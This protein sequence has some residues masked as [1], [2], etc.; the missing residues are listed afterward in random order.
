MKNT[1]IFLFVFP[2][3]GQFVS[4]FFCFCANGPFTPP[5]LHL[6]FAV[7][8]SLTVF[9][10]TGW[11]TDRRSVY[12]EFLGLVS[13]LRRTLQ[14]TVAGCSYSSSYIM[15]HLMECSILQR[16]S[17]NNVGTNVPHTPGNWS[18]TNYSKVGLYILHSPQ[19][20]FSSKTLIEF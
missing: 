11:S 14:Q 18:T 19:K 10:H 12:T 17:L 9:K 15:R 16:E 1:S 2:C 8:L 4:P 7:S 13:S 6:Q 20:V 5:Y 3:V